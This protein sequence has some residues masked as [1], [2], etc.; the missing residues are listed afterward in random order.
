MK[1]FSWSLFFLGTI[2][3]LA[4]FLRFYKLGEIPIE[5]NR[6]EASLGYTAF[7]ILKTGHE[8]HGVFWPLNIESFG[9]WKLPGYVYTLIPFVYYFGLTPFAVRL[10]SAIAGVLIVIMGWYLS[11]LIGIK[12]I[13]SQSVNLFANLTALFLAISPWELHLSH[14]AYEAHLAMLLLLGGTI[15]FIW[16]LENQ[17]RWKKYFLILSALSFGLTLFTYHSYQL[18][19][20][21]FALS[22]A[23]LYKKQVTQFFKTQKVVFLLALGI[24]LFFVGT[25]VATSIKANQTKFA[26]L[27]IFDQKAYAPIV[28][29]NR[30]YFENRNNIF[31]K[32]HTNYPSML[33]NQIQRNVSD[34]YSMRFFFFEGGTHGSHD[35]PGTGKMYPIELFFLLISGYVILKLIQQQKLPTQL[36]LILIWLV[37]ASLAPII[38]FEAAHTIRFSPALFPLV[39]LS[40]FG[41]LQLLSFTGIAANLFKL[42]FSG[43]LLY[44]CLYFLLTYFVIAPKRDL[45]MHNWQ[46]RTLINLINE[47]SDK[48]QKI[49]MPGATWSPYIYFLFYNQVDPA[50]LD[51][52]VV[53]FPLGSDGFKHVQKLGK[54]D[55]SPVDWND[56]NNR[57]TLYV[58]KKQEIP[59]DKLESKNYQIEYSLTHELAKDEWVLLSH[60]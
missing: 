27:S 13:K 12:F 18:F 53:Y 55:F 2:V 5:L 25:L 41:F 40:A 3:L 1:K 34:L 22:L 36:K 9:D 16:S 31:A 54:V 37:L 39:F 33:I 11:K 14:M 30:S 60:P 45:N 35:I 57:N 17:I 4:L 15:L 43:L 59:G 32:I 38:T 56:H 42:L 47:R 46:M 6:D 51:Q 48:Y 44:S 23:W 10:P 52:Q 26:A 21:L 8:E 7:S 20:P 29:I 28:E 49:L 50:T 58:I 24:G 19:T